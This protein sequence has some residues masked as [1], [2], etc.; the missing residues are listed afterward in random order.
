M[1][2]CYGQFADFDWELNVYVCFF[3][4][5]WGAI[6]GTSPDRSG[7]P[8]GAGVRRREIGTDSRISSWKKIESYICMLLRIALLLLSN[9]WCVLKYW[10]VV[11]HTLLDPAKARAY[12]WMWIVDYWSSTL[13]APAKAGTYWWIWIV[14]DCRLLGFG[15]VCFFLKWESQYDSAVLIV[16]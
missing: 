6:L 13:L 10:I 2:L 11:C 5:N 12:W 3:W 7:N 9:D 15:V 4:Q 8:P 16:D 14:T 1:A